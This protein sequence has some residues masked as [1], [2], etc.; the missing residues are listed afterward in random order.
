LR[1]YATPSTDRALTPLGRQAAAAEATLLARLADAAGTAGLLPNRRD[2]VSA[3]DR[4]LGL[5]SHVLV[6]DADAAVAFYRE[7]GR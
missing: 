6:T 4:P 2:T 7:A 3:A 5:S 1:R